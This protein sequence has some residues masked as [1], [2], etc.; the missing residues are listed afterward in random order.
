VA[1]A[2]ETPAT[3]SVGI[4]DIDPLSGA[5]RGHHPEHDAATALD[6]IARARGAQPDWAALPLRDR[7]AV[8]RRFHDLLV[9]DADAMAT[10][11]SRSVGK[12][13]MDALAA[14]VMPAV[15]AARHYARRASKLLAPFRPASGSLGFLN[16]RTRVQRLPYGVVGIIAPWNYPLSIPIHEILPALLAGNT[17]VFKAAEET[18]AVGEQ[19][20]ELLYRAGVPADVFQHLRMRGASA[21]EAFLAEDGGVNLLMFTGSNRVG[22]LLMAK[23]A[24]TLTPVSLELGGN[25]PMIVCPDADLERAVGAV[26]WAGMS[27]SGQSCAGV[28]RIYVHRAVYTEFVTALSAAVAALRV[29]PDDGSGAGYDSDMGPLAKREQLETVRRQV[30]DATARGAVITAQADPGEVPS[31]GFWHPAMVLTDV[32]HEMALMREETFGPVVGVMPVEDLD[33]AVALAN[34]SDLGLTASVWS[35]DTRA[36]AALARR[37]QAGIVMVND[38]LLTH[39][40]TQNPWGGFKRSGIG[41]AHGDWAFDTVT[42]TQA[43]TT[44]ALPFLKRNL[45][46]HPYSKAGYDGLKGVITVLHGRGLMR[47]LGALGAVLRSLT[48]LF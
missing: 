26:L 13:R 16:Y 1:T 34:D 41:R 21:G 40:I 33:Q 12:P 11:I 47:R 24:E 20:A 42:Q 31:D 30:A 9:E 4:P 15:I 27:S 2:P 14:E 29:A 22:K 48:R 28:E 39:G 8:I 37:I 10:V 32:T 23:A 7:V 38:H 43:V 46:W 36:A 17:V 6:R 35:R 19:I 3:T 44:Q 18:I 45:W 25:D 5:L